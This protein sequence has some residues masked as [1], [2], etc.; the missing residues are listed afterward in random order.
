MTAALFA[1][2][3]LASRLLASRLLASHSQV[4][5]L[6]TPLG[7]RLVLLYD[8]THTLDP[9]LEHATAG[10]CNVLELCIEH[11]LG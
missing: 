11:L 8:E 4:V 1:S 5:R 6:D 3:L 7:F 9:C 2:R 10:L